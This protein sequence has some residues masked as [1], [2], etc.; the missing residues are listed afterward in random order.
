MYT[1]RRSVSSA[2]AAAAQTSADAGGHGGSSM[3]CA[4]VLTT[5]LQYIHTN[6]YLKNKLHYTVETTCAS[7]VFARDNTDHSVLSEAGAAPAG[8]T[9]ASQAAHG[10]AGQGQKRASCSA[11][12]AGSARR[13]SDRRPSQRQID[14]AAEISAGSSNN[15]GDGTAPERQEAPVSIP[16]NEKR[17]MAVVKYATARAAHHHVTA[18]LLGVGQRQ[19]GKVCTVGAVAQGVLLELRSLYPLYYVKK[20]GVKWRPAL[21]TTTTTTAATPRRFTIVVAVPADARW[22]SATAAET[23]SG[24]EEAAAQT[25]AS[26]ETPSVAPPQ[27]P[28]HVQE[29]V[30]ATVQY[31]QTRC[32]RLH[33]ALQVEQITFAVI[34]TSS[35]QDGNSITEPDRGENGG[36]VAAGPDA[37]GGKDGS[38][39][40][41]PLEAYK[42]HLESLPFVECK[43]IPPANAAAPLLS[44][45]NRINPAAVGETG[46]IE[47]HLPEDGAAMMC[48]EGSATGAPAPRGAASPVAVC[49]LKASKKNPLL[50]L[51]SEPE[52][53]LPQ[54]I[55]QVGSLKPEVL[56]MPKSLVPESLQ[57]ALLA[58]SNPHCIVLPF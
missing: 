49:V 58:T 22:E 12:G 40:I 41:S 9:A 13:R 38:T 26:I 55:K 28:I 31:V 1:P 23:R 7:T 21:S 17:A 36:H 6:K 5:T 44:P 11:G 24:N 51:D 54:I 42:R 16:E 48:V 32:M 10:R 19:D 15:T 25:T 29:A 43:S 18:V 20:D 37:S 8:G 33:A 53:A 45:V 52:V 56:V 27:V 47:Q 14:T 57:L 34:A 35:S 4:D 3:P 46:G 50:S 39:W 2:A 30:A